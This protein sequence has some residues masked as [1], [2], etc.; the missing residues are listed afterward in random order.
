[1]VN[2]GY[3][4]LGFFSIKVALGLSFTILSF[5]DLALTDPGHLLTYF[6]FFSFGGSVGC[7]VG[8]C[9]R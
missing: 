1:M 8:C 5:T 9:R 2:L 3:S 7:A 4:G 6:P